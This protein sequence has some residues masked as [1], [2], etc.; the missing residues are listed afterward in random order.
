MEEIHVPVELVELDENSF[1]ILVTATV[2]CIEGDFIVDTGASI[3]V[4]DQET[5]F[6][7]EPL[8]NA[9]GLHSGGIGGAIGEVRLVNLPAL[10]V[11]GRAI[12]DV[13]V[14]LLDLRYVNELYRDHL[15]RRVAGLLGSDF[16]MAHRAVIDYENK[17]L[18]LKVATGDSLI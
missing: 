6:S 5:P 13:Q 16:L 9:H 8:E 4:I 1:H 7:H 3:T 2:G 15:Q 10:Q 12:A 11:G 18:T 14:A 17:R